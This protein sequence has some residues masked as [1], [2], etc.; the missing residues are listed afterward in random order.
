MNV[1]VRGRG[2]CERLIGAVRN[3][4]FGTFVLR[5]GWCTD[6]FTSSGDAS[7]VSR[8]LTPEYGGDPDWITLDEM[9]SKLYRFVAYGKLW[10]SF[11]LVTYR[12]EGFRAK[13]LFSRSEEK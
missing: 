13:G 7:A 1:R 9:N 11:E 2:P 6:G 10:A 3:I 8:R 5:R 12:D 4:A